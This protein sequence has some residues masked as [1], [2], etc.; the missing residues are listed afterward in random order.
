LKVSQNAGALKLQFADAVS[1]VGGI[2]PVERS[3]PR[4]S[5]SWAKECSM[6]DPTVLPPATNAESD[7]NSFIENPVIGDMISCR[8]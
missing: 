8:R 6:S 5:D 7:K 4:F 2:N 3:A 1:V